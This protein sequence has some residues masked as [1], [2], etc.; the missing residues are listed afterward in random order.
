MYTFGKYNPANKNVEW[1]AIED[2]QKIALYSRL[3]EEV[4]R[5]FTVNENKRR[6]NVAITI[7]KLD[8]SPSF[9]K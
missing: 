8:S 5:K 1:N 9:L 4:K 3:I 2:V 6:P 7:I